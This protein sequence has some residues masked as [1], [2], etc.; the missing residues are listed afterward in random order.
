M[1]NDKIKVLIGDNTT[2]Y[3]IKLASELREMGVYAYTRRNDGTVILNSLE[4]DTPDVA[5][6]NLSVPEL[7]VISI[8]KTAKKSLSEVPSFIVVT[9]IKNSFIDRQLLENGASYCI[10]RPFDAETLC[11]AVKSVIKMPS[12]HDCNDLEILVTDMICRFGVPAHLKGYHYLRTAILNAI[13]DGS[14]MKSVTKQL[15]PT[16][17]R[18]YETTAPRVER[19]IR[20][21]IE[22]AWAKGTAETADSF[23]G[24]PMRN[25]KTRPT[26]S[27]FIALVTDKLR[28]QV[29]TSPL[30]NSFYQ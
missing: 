20:N 23:F 21:A 28:L 2:D 4:N 8:M 17:A 15:Y 16:V 1:K 9:D 7:D 5:V 11:S 6:V 25:Y 27:E 30:A 3:G 29:K 26:N 18:Q 22:V 19:A 13:N 14:V 10:A 24:Y 12:S